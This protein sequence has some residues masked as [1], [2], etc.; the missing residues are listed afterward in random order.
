M[1]KVGL[2]QVEVT[3][4][5]PTHLAGYF[6]DR[7]ATGTL[8]PLFVRA[9]VFD[10]G[11]QRSAIA[12][13]DICM[14]PRKYV[15]KAKRQIVNA[16][17]LEPTQVILS[18]THTHTAPA[19]RKLFDVPEEQTYMDT[20]LL[21]ALV[22]ALSSAQHNLRSAQVWLGS[23]VERGLA[24]CR[25]Y[26][27][28][29]GTVVTNPPKGHPDIVCPEAEIDHALTVFRFADGEQTLG[30]LVNI[31]NHADT[32]GGDK[33]SADWPG[34]LSR[35]VAHDFGQVPV[36]L[37][38]GLSGNVN[39]FDPTKMHV[40][41]GPEE[42]RRI[43]EGYAALVQEALAESQ[44]VHTAPLAALSDTFAAP[45]RRVSTEQLRAAQTLVDQEFS[46][47]G[48]NLTAEDLAKGSPV[49][50]QMFAKM[51]L[52]FEAQFGAGE[53]SEELEIG[54]MRLGDIAIVGLPGEPFSQIGMR[55]K[56]LSPYRHTC[57]MAL[58][59]GSAGY[60]PLQEHFGS[61]GYETRTTPGNRFRE[62]TGEVLIQRSVAALK[63]LT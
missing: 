11:S 47:D 59:N 38:Y 27:M 60:V 41:T 57:V 31:N 8:D 25:R 45:Y 5:E 12:V 2:S 32:T 26:R 16:T 37:L 30:V 22:K 39:H 15:L 35:I 33:V 19:P 9:V 17:G 36:M 4:S 20:V 34:H 49:V 14:L 61:G 24:F 54:V 21:P 42:A 44:Q 7:I 18:A 23:T 40:Q 50:E 55:I 58:A 53:G 46:G 63:R 62:D 13:A 3:P 29:D 51:L 43:G 48:G 56:E 28:K 6:N 52:E 1:L 10:D